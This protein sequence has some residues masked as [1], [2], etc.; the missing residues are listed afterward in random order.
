[1]NFADLPAQLSILY[2]VGFAIQQALELVGVWIEGGPASKTGKII[3]RFG[4]VVLALTACLVSGALVLKIT[5]SAWLNYV[6][7]IL[8]IASGTEGINS[9]VKF[10]AYTK[11]LTKEK[12]ETETQKQAITA[13]QANG[14]PQAV[15]EMNAIPNPRDK[16]RKEK[17]TAGEHHRALETTR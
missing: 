16:V 12:K 8:V 1:M 11:E 7:S 5:D 3:F 4:A 9:I 6:V 13:A 2:I 17:A 10:L 14:Q 15:V